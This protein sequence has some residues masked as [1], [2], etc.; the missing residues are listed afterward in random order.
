MLQLDPEYLGNV[1]LILPI[2]DFAAKRAEDTGLASPASPAIRE[3]A[4][5]KGPSRIVSFPSP[6]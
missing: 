1:P 6:P 2:P 5:N 4:I 3:S